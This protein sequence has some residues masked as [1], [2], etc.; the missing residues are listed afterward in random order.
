MVLFAEARADQA[1]V[2]NYV[3]E[4]F[5]RASGEKVSVAKSKV[6]FSENTPTVA[7]EEIAQIQGFEATLDLGIY[8]GMPTINGRVTK[9]TFAHLEEK[10]NKRLAGWQTKHLSLAGRNTLVQLTLSTLA[11]YNMQTAKLPRSLC[12]DAIYS[13]CN[14]PAHTGSGAVTYYDSSSGC[15]HD[16]QINTCP[17]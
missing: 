7:R 13:I 3:L 10:F 2:I 16:L 12:D 5:C 4:N 15:V 9:A 8:L 11:N 6:F 17:L 14:T 1:Y